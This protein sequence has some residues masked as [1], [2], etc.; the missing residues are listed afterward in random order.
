MSLI[1]QK[2]TQ[3]HSSRE[4]IFC[5]GGGEIKVDAKMNIYMV[6]LR[7]FHL[8]SCIIWVGVIHHDP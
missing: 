5:F 3:D 4:M 6:I 2:E 7:D 1:Q 8:T